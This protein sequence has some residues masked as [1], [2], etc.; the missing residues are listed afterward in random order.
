MKEL[1]IDKDIAEAIQIHNRLAY[2]GKCD[3]YDTRRTPYY[4]VTYLE[5]DPEEEQRR[6]G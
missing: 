6:S 5:I 3:S 4:T 1:S 2:F